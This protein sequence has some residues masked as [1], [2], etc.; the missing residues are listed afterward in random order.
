MEIIVCIKQVPETN[1]VQVDP[2]TGVLIREGI[3]T[4]M[5]PYDLFAIETALRIKEKMGGHVKVISMGPPQ[6]IEVIKEAFMMGADD[7]ILLSDKK[8]A[9][10]DVLAT[11]ILFLRE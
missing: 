8:F 5:N 9:G 7:G 6:A 11:A 2:V 3:D 4:K 1:K 10:A